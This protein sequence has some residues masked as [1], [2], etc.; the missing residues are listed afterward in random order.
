[1][2]FHKGDS[3]PDPKVLGLSA[4]NREK[5]RIVKWNS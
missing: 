2:F 4:V 1:M 5:I 3:E